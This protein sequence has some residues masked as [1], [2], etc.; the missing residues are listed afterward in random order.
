[1][2]KVS[3]RIAALRG[4]S[5]KTEEVAGGDNGV[6]VAV[7]VDDWG[8]VTIVDERGA[9]GDTR[10]D[11]KPRDLARD[12]RFNLLADLPASLDFYHHGGTSRLEQQVDLASGLLLRPRKPEGRCGEDWDAAKP[13]EWN[14]G[15]GIVQDEVFE[16]QAEDGVPSRKALKRREGELALADRLLVRFDVAQIEARVVVADAESV[17]PRRTAGLRIES[18]VPRDETLLLQDGKVF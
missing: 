18:R 15:H 14:E 7:G 6:E 10:G 9:D 17:L 5:A 13:Q 8:E 11:G 16:L 1:M 4:L 3:C 2:G 12:F